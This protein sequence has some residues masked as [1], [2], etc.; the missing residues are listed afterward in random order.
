[1]GGGMCMNPD[2]KP[3]APVTWTTYAAF[4]PTDSD[5][6]D[7]TFG[8]AGSSAKIGALIGTLNARPSSPADWFLVGFAT[9]VT[10]ATTSPIC[11]SVNDTCHQ[12]NT[13]IFTASVNA[14]AE[15]ESVL[16]AIAG[17]FVAATLR[18]KRSA[19]PA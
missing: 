3:A 9:T 5:T 17:C 18:R 7:R 1:M 13:G 19:C 16:L 10:L 11:A 6:A 14:V 15:P 8:R 2:G 12:N 4:N